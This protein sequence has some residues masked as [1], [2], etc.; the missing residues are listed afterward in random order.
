MLE[1]EGPQL[2]ASED[3]I[4]LSR[5][6]PGPRRRPALPRKC[7][8]PARVFT[9]SCSFGTELP[10]GP[11]AGAFGSSRWSLKDLATAA[12]VNSPLPS[13]LTPPARCQCC[14][15]QAENV[16]LP[17]PAACLPISHRPWFCGPDAP[18]G[19]PATSKLRWDVRSSDK[20]TGSLTAKG[21]NRS[22]LGLPE[23]VRVRRKSTGL[24]VFVLPLIT[25]SMS[26]S[27]AVR[28]VP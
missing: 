25:L 7:I 27:E 3:T 15:S 14:L 10:W 17:R 4:L 1:L 9:G 12:S 21:D 28:T 18:S 6:A 19:I 20:V 13:L 11:S 22:V 23:T 2:P 5:P 26:P 24:D 8:P 16:V